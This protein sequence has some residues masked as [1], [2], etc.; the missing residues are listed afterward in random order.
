M[1]VLKRDSLPRGGFAGLKETRLIRDN[2]INGDDST[3]NGL[4]NFYF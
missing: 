4:G 2:S 1:K 3:W